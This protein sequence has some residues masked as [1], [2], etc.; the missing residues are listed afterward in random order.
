[1]PLNFVFLL[2]MSGGP[3]WIGDRREREPGRCPCDHGQVLP[4]Y[5]IRDDDRRVPR[6]TNLS[7]PSGLAG[8]SSKTTWRGQV[9][10]TWNTPVIITDEVAGQNLTMIAGAASGLALTSITNPTWAT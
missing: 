5:L 1:M 6:R 2:P 7:A 9:G 3:R 10:T 4:G 8:D